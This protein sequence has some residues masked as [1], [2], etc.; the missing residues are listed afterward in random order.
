MVRKTVYLDDEL[1]RS[2][3]KEVVEKYGKL[4][5]LSKLVNEKLRKVME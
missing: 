5:G 4:R 1:Y 2:L 3:I